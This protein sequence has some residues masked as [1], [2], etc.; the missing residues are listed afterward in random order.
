M[1]S[2]WHVDMPFAM[3]V[4][5]MMEWGTDT[6]SAADATADAKLFGSKV[7]SRGVV[8]SAMVSSP[9][10]HTAQRKLEMKQFVLKDI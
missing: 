3:G 6:A 5:L 7:D 1:R 10:M 4:S 8:S 9:A 2:A